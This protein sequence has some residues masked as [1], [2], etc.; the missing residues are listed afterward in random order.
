MDVPR[1]RAVLRNPHADADCI[2][3][4]AEFRNLHSAYEFRRDVVLHRK[5]PPM[6]AARF[7]PALYWRDLARVGSSVA[8]RPALRRGSDQ[9]VLQRLPRLTLGEQIALSRIAGVGLLAELGR[10]PQP[11]VVGALLEN[12]RLTEG[13]VLRIVSSTSTSAAILELVAGS[14][15]GA[16]YPVRRALCRNP[17]TPLQRALS[18]VATLRKVDQRALVGDASVPQAVRRRARL[19]SQGR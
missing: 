19:L 16:R 12:P 13:V 5:S 9:L 11:R 18:L 2:A 15:W 17:R 10:S 1:A 7:L 3:R 14:R 8:L 6:L 4:L